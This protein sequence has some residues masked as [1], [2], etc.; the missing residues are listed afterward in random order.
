MMSQADTSHP[1]VIAFFDKATYTITYVVADQ[2]NGEC[3][4]IDPVMDYDPRAARTSTASADA[5]IALIREKH[6][7]NRWILETHA[8]ADHLTGAQYIKQ[9]LGGKT[10]IGEHIQAVQQTF[11]GL[12]NLGAGFATDGSQFDRLV[13][14]K[15]ELPLGA[16]SIHVMHTP[17]HTPACVSYLIGDAVFVGDTIF[18][19]D[20]GTARA[21]FPGG[22]ARTLYRS[23]RRIL[24]LPRST[25]VF[26]CHDYQP[27]GREPAW[28]STVE[29]QRQHNIQIRDSVNEDSYVERRQGRD[30]GLAAPVLIWPSLQVN[31]RAGNLPEAD[32]NGIAYLRLPLNVLGGKKS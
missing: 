10:V 31:I 3:V 4:V 6:W 26:T 27:G 32:D 16:F 20:Y 2:E 23:I 11:S 13:S 1:E 24:A 12:F 22:D 8:H 5:V 30:A 28:E 21:D 25:R 29:Q 9:E 7:K 19:P 15:E 18:M 17:G 14:D